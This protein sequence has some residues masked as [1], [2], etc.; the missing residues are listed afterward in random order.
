MNLTPHATSGAGG[1]AEVEIRGQAYLTCSASALSSD[2]CSKYNQGTRWPIR[3]QNPAR[4]IR[5]PQSRV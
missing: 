5:R 1:E 3:L 4:Q 2:P